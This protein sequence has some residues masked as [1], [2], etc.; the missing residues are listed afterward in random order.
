MMV[1]VYSQEF[2]YLCGVRMDFMYLYLCRVEGAKL[3]LTDIAMMFCLLRGVYLGMCMWCTYDAL[4]YYV[5]CVY[6]CLWGGWIWA[7]E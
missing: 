4:M 5:V 6:K 7:R 2:T 3:V 1:F